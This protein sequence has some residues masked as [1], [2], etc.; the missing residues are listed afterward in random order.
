MKENL[1]QIIYIASA[2]LFIFGLKM[3]SRPTTAVRGNLL[4]AV[5]MG[6]AIVATLMT[7]GLSM[8]WIVAGLVIGGVIG[9]VAALKVPMTSMPEFVAVFNGTGGLAS[10]LVGCAEYYRYWSH[11]GGEIEAV[12]LI[13]TYLAV[14]IGGV[15]FTGSMVAYAKLAEKID[16]KPFL[17]K[18]QQLINAAVLG[19]LALGGVVFFLWPHSIIAILFFLLAVALSLVLGV[20][21]TIPIG[22][23]DMPVVIS[24]LNSYS[25]LAGCAAG[26]V[27]SNT[28]LIVAGSLVGA[29]GII[30][31]SIMC[32]AMN[33]SLAN[34]LFSGFGSATAGA[35]KAVEGE[36]RALSVEDAFFVLE[37]ASSVVFVP[38]YGMAVAQAQHAVRELG[39]IL[40]KNGTEVKYAIHPVAGRMPGHMNVLLAEANVP[41]EQLVE[42]DDINP[43]I[44]SVDV[45]VVIGANDVVNP[46]AREDDSSPI[47]GMPV[48]NVDLA[49]SCFVIKRSMRSGFAGIENP[50]F[51][52]ENTR[53]VFGDAKAVITGLVEQFKSA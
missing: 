1:I 39:D 34:V 44:E 43:V 20:L 7:G 22:G 17:F 2:I 47:Y 19:L 11:G 40:E 45:C 26:F 8:T 3:M 28:V 18:N 14:L 41:Y 25:G 50:L 24:L 10:M 6:L 51:Y 21:V 27:I 37:S 33:R 5:G 48:I 9:T 49:K 32:K 53:M 16:S 31:T 46:A 12:P 4:S 15:T 52:K 13:A 38:G 29:S 23:A 42:M 35:G 36:V 30:L